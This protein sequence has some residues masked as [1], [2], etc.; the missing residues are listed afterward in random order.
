[1]C[2]LFLK[3]AEH[4]SLRWWVKNVK[5]KISEEPPF[6]RAIG[7]NASGKVY[8]F[9]KMIFLVHLTTESVENHHD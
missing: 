8:I 5:A 7:K 1:M 2:V 4:V 3:Q 6:N 9:V